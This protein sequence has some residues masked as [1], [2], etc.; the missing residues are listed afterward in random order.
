MQTHPLELVE[1]LVSAGF[2]RER[3]QAVLNSRATSMVPSHEGIRRILA[4]RQRFDPLMDSKVGYADLVELRFQ[5][6][7]P[8]G[9]SSFSKGCV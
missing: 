1:A 4:L 6:V 3:T 9:V 5:P 8:P 2:A 7:A